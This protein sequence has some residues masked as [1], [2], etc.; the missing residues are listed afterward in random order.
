MRMTFKQAIV[1]TTLCG[2]LMGLTGCTSLMP[3]P[4]EPTPVAETAPPKVRRVP[5]PQKVVAAAPQRVVKKKVIQP[6]EE[7]EEPVAVACQDRSCYVGAARV[8]AQVEASG[9]GWGG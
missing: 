6:V 5:P 9:G 2:V 1:G 7:E 3:P 8:A 4:P